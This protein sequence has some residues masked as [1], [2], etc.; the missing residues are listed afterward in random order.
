MD[1]TLYLFDAAKRIKPGGVITSGIVQLIHKERARTLSAEIPVRYAAKPGEYLG[2][3]CVDGRFRLFAIE[4][5]DDDDKT[6]TTIITATDAAKDE[7]TG[8]ILVVEEQEDAQVKDEAKALIEAAGW[9][10]GIDQVGEKVTNIEGGLKSA[11]T[12]LEALEADGNLFIHPYY[13]FDGHAITGRVVDLCAKDPVKCGRLVQRGTDAEN[14]VIT[15][16]NRPRPMIFPMGEDGMTIADAVWDTKKGDPVDKPAGQ[17]WIGV[18]EAVAA[19][20]GQGQVMTVNTDDQMEMMAKGWEKAQQATT[21]GMT[22]TATISDMEMIKGQTW[23]SIRL[24]Y[25]VRVRPRFGQDAEAQVIEIARNYVRNDQTK[26]TL[27]EEPDSSAKALRGLVKTAEANTRELGKYKAQWKDMLVTVRELD[28]Y[29]RTTITQAW[30]DLKAGT[31]SSFAQI[32]SR[33]DNTDA[34]NEKQFRTLSESMLTLQNDL[35]SATAALVARL[36]KAEG[37]TKDVSEALLLLDAEMGSATA[38]LTARVNENEAAIILQASEL[39]TR[40]DLKADVTYVQRLVANEIAAAKS[41]IDYAISEN[42]LTNYLIAYNNIQSYGWIEAPTV[43]A[44]GG[45]EFKGESVNKTTISVVTGIS[46]ATTREVDVLATDVGDSTELSF[47]Q[48]GD[49]VGIGL[50]KEGKEMAVAGEIYEGVLYQ[51]SGFQYVVGDPV[52]LT[53]VQLRGTP[54]Q[55]KLYDADGALIP[56]KLYLGDGGYVNRVPSGVT[57]VYRPGQYVRTVLDTDAWF[58]GGTFC[59]RGESV[60]VQGDEFTDAVFYTGKKV[61]INMQ[62]ITA[63]TA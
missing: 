17:L 6:A 31:E 61:T 11:W 62:E 51:A 63:L 2:F 60:R 20:P 55:G 49:M 32:G 54:Y 14:I 15:H 16:K 40:I 7:L 42:I 1:L 52:T 5:A 44:T 43:R 57:E 23:K 58:G 12:A 35:D 9:T 27:G 50:Y 30:L 56:D 13:E 21:P 59:F 36:T 22:A 41:E 10:V 37:T 18:P 53:R 4:Y 34:Q 38:A 28:E 48:R 3:R 24:F 25:I 29:T 46:G 47:W 26:I 33:L 45:F 8:T 39:G 19:Y